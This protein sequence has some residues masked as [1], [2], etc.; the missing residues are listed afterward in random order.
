[1][2]ITIRVGVVVEVEVAMAGDMAEE[3]G[4]VEV[5]A[6]LVGDLGNPMQ[7]TTSLLTGRS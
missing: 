2:K 6:I 3:V 1:V 7:V 4:M 5:A